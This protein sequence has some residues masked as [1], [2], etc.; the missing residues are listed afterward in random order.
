MNSPQSYIDRLDDPNTGKDDDRIIVLQKDGA[1]LY[2]GANALSNEKIIATH[3][4][5]D[6]LGLHAWGAKGSW[7]VLCHSDA[8][9]EF[10]D[11]LVQFAAETALKH[12]RSELRTVLYARILD[13]FKPE[14]STAGVWRSLRQ[15]KI[16]L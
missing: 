12:S 8:N 5:K 11:H 9:V 4:H 15:E 16:E 13:L 14:N 10:T 7:V 3:P 6:C 1:V 2:I